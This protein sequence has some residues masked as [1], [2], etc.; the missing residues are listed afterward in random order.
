MLFMACALVLL[1]AALHAGG[2]RQIVTETADGIEIWQKEFDVS[3][4]KK[5]TYNIII[6]AKDAAG[7]EGIGG[8]FNIKIDPMAGLPEARVVYPEH[9]QVVREDVSIVGVAA[10]RYGIKQ[11]FVKID[12]GEYE[13]LEGS[14]YWNYYIP[15]LDLAEGNHTVCVKATDNH[16]LEGPESKISF[17]LDLTPP[18][19]ELIDLQIGDLIAGSVKI[20]GRVFDA[21]GVQS[22]ALSIDGGEHFT[23][24]G[25]SKKGGDDGR[26]FQF[27]INSKKFEDGPLVCYLRATNRTGNSITRPYLFFVNNFPPQIEIISPGLKEDIF[28]NTQV[29]GQVLTGV[30]LTEFYY[31]WA[32]EKVS[33]P[34]RPG[35]P[36]WS[37]TFPISMANNRAIPFRI[38]AIDKSGNVT[39][40]SQRFQDTRKNRTPA[41]TLDN[42]PAPNNVGRMNL[43]WNQPIYGHILPGFFPYAV[44]LEGEIEY[45]MAQPCFR[46]DPSLIPEGRTTLRMWAIDE[47]DVTGQVYTLRINKAA[48]PPG[49][50][51]IESPITIDSPEAY[52]W[53]GES[54]TIRGA[55]DHYS[56]GQTLEYRFNW[57]DFWKPV[58]VNFTGAFTATISLADLPEGP[59]PL[60]FRT[61]RNGEADYPR[62]FPINKFITQ[63]VISF[64]VPAEEYG[65]IHGDVTTAGLVDYF[66]PL[67]EISY[68]ID[69]FTYEKLDFVARYN[70]AWFNNSFDYSAM[71]NQNQQLIIR[72]VDRAGNRVQAS[73]NII[74]DNS[75]DFP[76]LILNSPLE[77]EIISGDFDVSG[78]AFDDD[79]VSM[80][81]WRILNPRNPWDSVEE[82]LRQGRNV[83]FDRFEIVQNFQF[84]VSLY[85]L[86]DGENIIEIYVEDMYGV[87][88][89]MI[90]RVFRVSTMPPVTVVTAPPMDI[91]NRGN[92]VVNGTAFDLNGIEDVL[93]SM[94]NGVS[95]QRADCVSSQIDPS[96]WHISLNTKAYTD[97]V[98]SMLVRT[99][100]KYGISSFASGIVNIDNTPPEIDLGSPRNGDKIGI[101]LAITG[102]VYDSISTKRISIHVVNI[103]NPNLQRAYD[104]PPQLVIMEKMDVSNFPDGDYTL[105][106]AAYDQSGN[107]TSVVSNFNILKARAASEV[108]LIN[109]LPGITHNGPLVVSGKITG[110][111]IPEN[112]TLMLNKKVYTE[113]EVNRYGIFR[114]EL[115]EDAVTMDESTIFSAYFY[116]PGEERIVSFE[117]E[118]QINSHGPVLEVDSHHDGDVI[119]RRPY[120]SGRAFYILPPEENEEGEDGEAAAEP[121]AAADSEAVVE[122]VEV[123]AKAARKDGKVAPKAKKVELSFDNGRTFDSAKG[124]E[125]WKYRLETGELERGS[126]PIVIK[127]TFNDDSVAVRRIMLIVD[128]RPPLVNTIGPPENSSHRTEVLVY[129]SSSDDFDMDTVEVSLRP[130]D[131]NLYAVP[132]FIQGLYFDASALG[133]LS[134]SMG[135]GLT[136]FDDNVKVQFNAANAGTDNRY[137]GWAF[138]LKILANVYTK[139]LSEWF[140][141]DWEFYT[142]SLTVGAHFS[143][144]LMDKGETPLW[145]GQL[146][147]QWEMIKAD[148]K[149]FFPKWKYFKTISIYTEPGI[150]FAPS[151][152]AS[153]QAWRTKFTI[154]F[155]GRISLF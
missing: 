35:D 89:E 81:Y 58:S 115:P 116:T 33:I 3:G 114:H 70:R 129:G 27:P 56:A 102:Q 72:A 77:D 92:I 30:G 14:E 45:I 104:L 121:D 82:T 100:D 42:P 112:V 101:E 105:T 22:L 46:I 78:I 91:W 127:A 90:Q 142:T 155:G 36:F 123:D 32:G 38:T 20:R 24:L 50:E 130:G 71:Q 2:S 52:D 107:E 69:G 7:N 61:V 76:T 140:G 13:E 4:R 151:D 98:Y 25:L 111:V 117:H 87:S 29:T 39:T 146:I 106:V 44:I 1:P 138:G 95:Y 152:V 15:S 60:E 47:G 80:V 51:L 62:Y 124:A 16:D 122:V 110:A 40:I 5:G 85:D 53:F 139:N 59:V 135:V 96:P 41:L 26:F 148:M 153:E 65:T 131:K 120:I 88:S 134:Y 49:A 66:V 18:A 147:G 9:G 154:G 103:E 83:E 132:G 86:R 97:G 150:W 108:A 28:G 34:L 118:V 125:K 126:L 133:G 143:Y 10:A 19:V 109:P 6:T 144:F 149:Y 113:I 37:V 137:S 99:I 54:V 79:A 145:M 8:P 141:P 48:A 75:T 57:E 68:S 73:P 63:P 11:I 94:D 21:N 84:P 128:T 55:I 119:T 12:D 64:L 136:F 17:I 43:E 67:R 74:F 93:V 23:N 31:E